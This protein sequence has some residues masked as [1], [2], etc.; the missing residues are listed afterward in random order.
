[1]KRVDSCMGTTNVTNVNDHLA[2]HQYIETRL[3]VMG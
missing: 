3:H 1:M 2:K